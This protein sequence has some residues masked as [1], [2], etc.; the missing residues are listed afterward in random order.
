MV[1]NSQHPKVYVQHAFIAIK[2]GINCSH[3]LNAIFDVF[4]VSPFLFD[5][6]FCD[7]PLLPLQ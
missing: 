5:F 2:V 1:E 7:V 6:L 3:L 4:L